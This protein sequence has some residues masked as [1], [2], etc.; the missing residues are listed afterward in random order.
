M[1]FLYSVHNIQLHNTGDG[2]RAMREELMDTD[3]QA[4]HARKR[5]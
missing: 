5:M 2:G 3:E 1:Y 4:I